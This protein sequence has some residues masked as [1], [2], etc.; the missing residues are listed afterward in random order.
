MRV[1]IIGKVVISEI[2]RKDYE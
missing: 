2:K 1:K